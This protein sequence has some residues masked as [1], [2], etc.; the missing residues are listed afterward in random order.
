MSLSTLARRA[1]H[2]LIHRGGHGDAGDMDAASY[3]RRAAPLL[4]GL[5]RRV[6]EDL[7]GAPRGGHLLDVGCGTGRL[8]IEVARRRDDLTL[9]GIDISPD[10]IELAGRNARRSVGRDID[11]RVGDSAALPLPDASVDVV[12]STLSLHHWEAPAAAAHELGRVLRPGGR[13]LIYDFRMVSTDMLTL[14]NGPF[15]GAAAERTLIRPAS[16]F[17]IA[18]FARTALEAP[19]RPVPQVG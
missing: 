12:V 7:S 14:A 1:V 11:F 3:D 2:A 4:R 8:L 13:L 15:A 19:R 16:W 6:A 10:M 9:T 5:Y 17:P 18:I